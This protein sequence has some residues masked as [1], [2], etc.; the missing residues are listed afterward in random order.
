VQAEQIKIW[1]RQ[2][3][4]AP[5]AILLV[6]RS[7]QIENCLRQCGCQAK[8]VRSGDNR[9]WPEATAKICGNSLG[10]AL[11]VFL[12]PELYE[13]D[14]ENL[15]ATFPA[16]QGRI[17]VSCNNHTTDG[18]VYDA[19]YQAIAVSQPKL[20]TREPSK[21]DRV[22]DLPH[23]RPDGYQRLVDSICAIPTVAQVGYR[24]GAGSPHSCS[25]VGINIHVQYEFPFGLVVEST[26][27]HPVH[28]DS[29]REQ[30]AKLLQQ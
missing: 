12:L 30:I 4:T 29:L 5:E 15:L 18:D 25:V 27:G 17:I 21:K 8:V 7:Y 10:C 3:I 14:R 24:K 20:S 16:Q 9:F 6:P 2:C 19:L 13:Q 28:L 11:C 22:S 26:S 23:H 1:M